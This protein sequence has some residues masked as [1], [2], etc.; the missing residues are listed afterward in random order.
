MEGIRPPTELKLVGNVCD[1]WRRFKQRFELYLEATDAT[2]KS[3]A[4]KIALFLTSAGNQ[5]IEVYNTLTLS[6]DDMKKYDKI[7]E[8]FENHCTPLVNETFER[9]IFRTRVQGENE[10]IE[11]FVTDLRLKSQSCNFEHLAD[12]L[13]RDQVVYGI[14]NKAIRERLLREQNLTLNR[15]VE[16]CLAAENAAMQLHHLETDLARNSLDVHAIAGKNNKYSGKSKNLSHKYTPKH[17]KNCGRCGYKHEHGKCAAYGQK[18]KK[19]GRQ[20]HFAKCCKTKNVHSVETQDNDSSDEFFV[21]AIHKT[22]PQLAKDEWV[23]PIFIND[24]VIPFKIDTGSQVNILPSHK[25]ETLKFK[26]AIDKNAP[27]LRSYTGDKIATQGMCHVKAKFNDESA[28]VPMVITP[29]N[30]QP[31][32][33]LSTCIKLGLV[34]TVHVI[35]EDVVESNNPT[36]QISATELKEN[37]KNEFKDV[38]TGIGCLPG[39]HSIR[40]KDDAVPVVHAPRKI[41]FAQRKPLRQEL[42]RL[43]N[44]EFIKQV[45]EPTDWVNSP[46]IVP[47]KTGV[48]RLCMDPKDLNKNIRRE[49]EHIPTRNEITHEMANAKY[50][51]KLDM[52]SGFWQVKLDEASSKLCTFNTPFGRFRWLRLPFGLCS[53]PEVFH[54]IIQTIYEN[55]DGVETCHDDI[56][57]Y[58]TTIQE[59]D[60]RLYA[61]L[62]RARENNMTLNY[63]KCLFRVQDLIF[64]GDRLTNNGIQPDPNKVSAIIDMPAPESTTDLQRFLGMVNYVGKFIPNLSVKT[65]ALRQLLHKDSA[66]CWNEAH[67]TELDELKQCLVK[68]PILQFFDPNKEIK[69]STDAS[70]SGIGAVLLQKVDDDWLPISYASRSMTSAEQR[71]AQIEKELL[72]VVYGCE[73]FHQYIYGMKTAI[74]TDHKPLIAITNKPLNNAPPRLQRLM[75]RLQKYDVELEWTPGKFLVIADTLSRAVQP[76]AALSSTED[77]ITCHVDAIK[78]TLPISQEK[79]KIIA[80]ETLNDPELQKVQQQV[81]NGW[82]HR[83]T[84]Q[85]YHYREEI[86]S[87]DGVLL[88]GTRIIIPN[89]LRPDMLSRIHE[90]HLGIEKCKRRARQSV[91]WPKMNR[92]IELTVGSC[93]VCQTHRYKQQKE[94]LNEHNKVEKPW[95]KLGVDLFQLK[96]KDYMLVTDYFSSYPE[97]ALLNTTS[98]NMVIV[99]L[100]SIMARHGLVSEIVTDNGPQFVSQEFSKFANEYGFKH[101]TSSPMFP[102]SNGK[103]ENGVKIVKNILIKAMEAK[104]DPYLALLAYRASPLECGKSPA[105][106]LMN[107]QLRTTLPVSTDLLATKKKGDTNKISRNKKNYDKN[108]KVHR[109][110]NKH[111]T[112]RIRHNGQWKVKARVIKEVA[113][114]SYVVETQN[115]V[116]Y[117]RNRRDLMPTIEPFEPQMNMRNPTAI[118]YIP[119]DITTHVQPAGNIQTVPVNNENRLNIQNEPVQNPEPPQTSQTTPR[120][121]GRPVRTPKRLIEEN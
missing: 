29:N 105:E 32:L 41:P 74:E 37:V 61:A 13:I 11:Q 22:G 34:K 100:K 51:S 78:S 20:N 75:I 103:A 2:K 7:I 27:I 114:R 97:F 52:S 68:A 9:Y 120:R 45:N 10:N 113:P 81:M 87:V 121:S 12:G 117:R 98:T 59:H 89:N 109:P 58:G 76:G 46:V 111:E 90:G 40:L 63:D 25:F 65:T 28:K 107:R 72:G 44:M 119:D 71:Y 39:T 19:C 6:A 31:I 24:T 64:L 93:S 4:Q 36:L 55:T 101:T 1:N 118:V 79:W 66:W 33:G 21:G 70:K 8:A 88:K 110:L 54:K 92:D 62:Q 77:E 102:Q 38:F 83:R 17:E 43:I 14:R 82:I 57:V 26:P 95:D 108:A 86:T 73:Q 3:D 49:Y 35:N 80:S 42:D 84:P 94:P 112:V 16:I 15:A 30:G 5:A 91:Y 116:T 47:K 60:T 99:H 23:V 50:F 69:L 18:C 48:I 115:G 96:G 106:L 56:V 104:D 67:Q 85:Y 53:A